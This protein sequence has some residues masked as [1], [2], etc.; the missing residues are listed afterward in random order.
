MDINQE[1]VRESFTSGST[2]GWTEVYSS[3]YESQNHSYGIYCALAPADYAERALQD[4][5]WDLTMTDG[6]P[7]F[8]QYYEGGEPRTEY[9][10]RTSRGGVEPLVL[11]R[12]FHGVRPNF[13][14]ISEEFR[15]YH[16]LYWDGAS[17]SFVKLKDDGI[18]ETVVEM[19][20]DRVR[21]R[22]KYLRQYQ[23]ARQMCLLLFVDSVRWA[24]APDTSLPEDVNW[25]DDNL[26]LQRWNG[27]GL[28]ADTGFTRLLGTRVMMPP[29]IEKSGVWPFDEGN[30]KFPEFIIGTDDDGDDVTYTC[31]HELLANYFGAN[32]NAPHY[33]TPV[34]FRREVLRK[35][36]DNPDLYRVEDGY[37]RCA[38]LW[39]LQMDN[40]HEDR[41]VVFLGDLGRDLPEGERDYWRSFNIAPAGSMSETGTRRSFLAQF[42]EPKAADLRFR[43]AYTRFA[44][45]WHRNTGFSLF[46]E[47]VGS[48]TQILQQIRLPL[49][50]SESEFDEAVG[51]LAKLLCD[52]LDSKA[53]QAQLPSKVDNEASISKLQRWLEQ[54]NYPERVRDIQLL[55]DLQALRSKVSA[56]SKGS[57]YQADLS[58]V[59]GDL[60]GRKAIVS[61]LERAEQMLVS[62]Q[63]WAKSMDKALPADDSTA[64]T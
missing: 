27:K 36:Y 32:P 63:D 56:H 14:E 59:L 51:R 52:G 22:T 50:E 53:I 5:G 13:L 28:T 1:D 20:V 38:G 4:P 48:D 21:I 41:V 57:K 61:L 10:R 12:E 2:D 54:E 18:A 29:P 3:S 49:N 43:H 17:S 45:I 7:G 26:N 34:H 16:N 6:A 11:Y 37:V 40:D 31:E 58:K 64:Q 35:Y 8:S 9:E 47:P 39:G 46:R 42:A 55:R 25:S 30:E 60:R 62:L 44:D 15:L 33:L 19:G 23:A 24:E